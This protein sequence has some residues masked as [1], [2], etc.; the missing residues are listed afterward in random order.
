MMIMVFLPVLM[1][2]WMHFI[3]GHL[4]LLAGVACDWLMQLWRLHRQEAVNT[5][6]RRRAAGTWPTGPAATA[7][8][9]L[10]AIAFDVLRPRTLNVVLLQCYT[11]EAGIITASERCV[12]SSFS[13]IAFSSF[14]FTHRNYDRV[15]NYVF[16]GSS[17]RWPESERLLDNSP[18]NQ[19][20]VSPVADWSTRGLVHL[21]TASFY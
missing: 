1:I 13:V 12:P 20:A 5:N 2:E 19:L 7:S 15:Q 9:S 10:A 11:C 16:D 3:N 8:V 4:L 21:P 18:T 6:R 17:T 14:L